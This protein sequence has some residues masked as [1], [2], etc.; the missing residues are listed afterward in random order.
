MVQL[1]KH[2]CWI[3]MIHFSLLFFFSHDSYF[4][5]EILRNKS[6]YRQLLN[7]LSLTVSVTWSKI[8]F[9]RCMEIIAHLISSQLSFIFPFSNKEI[10]VVTWKW[11]TR[12][13][14]HLPFIFHILKI[15]LFVA[16][17]CTDRMSYHLPFIFPYSNKNI[18]CQDVFQFIRLSPRNWMCHDP[19]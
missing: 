18:V 17:K 11:V 3:N 8:F 13:S 7:K 19:M 15:K 4:K 14:Y 12:I 9:F 6:E 16:W 5:M 10:M 1:D 2:H